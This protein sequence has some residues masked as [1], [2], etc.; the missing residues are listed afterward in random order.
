MTEP[1]PSREQRLLDHVKTLPNLPG[2]YRYLSADGTVLY[3]G[4]ARD[5][6]KRVSSYFQKT[7]LSPRIRLMLGQVERIETTV[8]RSEAE[9][10]VLEN[11]LIKA[12]GPRY[13]ILFRDDKSYPYLVVT[14]HR[15]PRLA[16][17]RGALDK[18]NQYFGPFPNGYVVK[19]SIQLLQKVFKLRTCEDTVFANRSRPCLLHQIKRC[20]AP[21]VELVDQE[22]YRADVN[23]AVLFLQGK[24]NELLADLEARMQAASE[25]WDFETA[26]ALRDQIQA[27]AKVQE[28]QFV[29]SNTNELDADIVACVA[30]RGMLCVN[31]AMV[32]G[33]RHVG[34][35]SLF[36]SHADDYGPTEALSAFLAQHYLDRNVPPVVICHPA[37]DD[38]AVLAE[39]L[40]EQAGRKVVLNCNPNGERRV[41]LD[42]ARKNAEFAILQ[43]ASQAASQAG[44][45]TALV[46]AMNLPEET[47]RIE[48]FDISHTMGEATVASCV[49]FDRG[50]MQPKEYRRY[51][52]EGITA[53]DDYAAMKQV[54]TRRYGKIAAGEGVVPDLILIDGGKGQLTQAE[55]VLAEVGLT[56]PIL[57]GVAKGETRKAGLEQLIVATSHEVIRLPADHPGLH[58]IQQIRDESHRFAITGHRARRAKAR[59]AS[60]LEEIDGVGPKRR[61][62][63]LSRFGGLQG[64]KGAS[65]EDLMQVDGINAELAERIYGALRG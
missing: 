40:S 54:L 25:A 9:A 56:Q 17:Y 63:L 48:C 58:L 35:K 26:A 11:N 34:D 43:R 49:V 24:A 28:R 10:L 31:L 6:K 21:C 19:E 20:S 14:G 51:N 2:V 32:R 64:V 27:L 57:L 45:L 41:W 22:Q 37:P 59:V 12:L 16:Y 38:A 62:R 55:E 53:G 52:I 36:P 23:H 8:V 1:A 50:D 65:V 3:V 61:Q 39:L 33:G 42:M 7:D 46:E 18:R 44:R 4:K 13:N 60:S 5:L 29:S 30:D 47:Q 15:Y